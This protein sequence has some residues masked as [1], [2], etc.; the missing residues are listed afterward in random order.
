MNSARRRKIREEVEMDEMYQ[1]EIDMEVKRRNSETSMQDSLDS[2]EEEEKIH[3]VYAP[4]SKRTPKSVKSVKSVKP[5]YSSQTTPQPNTRNYS[6]RELARKYKNSEERDRK[7]RQQF[8][9]SQDNNSVSICDGSMLLLCLLIAF[10]SIIVFFCVR[11]AKHVFRFIW[12]I[13]IIYRI[14]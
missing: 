14:Q 1:K 2:S 12:S 4:S 10:F 5:T 7:I 9:V 13:H 6:E 11:A 3:Y 8:N